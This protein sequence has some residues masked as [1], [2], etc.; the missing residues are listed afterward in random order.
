MR[1][2]EAMTVRAETIGPDEALE[3]AARRMRDTGIGALPVCESDRLVGMITDRD[4]VVRGVAA[5]LA[6]GAAKVRDAMTA[7]VVYCFE[8]DELGRGAELMEQHAVRRVMVLDRQKRLVGLLS[9][10]D[11]AMVSRMLAAEVIEHSRE[12][13]LPVEHGGAP[14]H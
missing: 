14:A 1:V 11:L 3:A 7:Q 9:V 12:P 5:G 13:T 8:D 4:I 6:P 10:D 2:G